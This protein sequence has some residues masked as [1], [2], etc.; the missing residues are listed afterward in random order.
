[1]KLKLRGILC[2]LFFLLGTQLCF[3]RQVILLLVDR[4][5]W[6]ELAAWQDQLPNFRWLMQ[7]GALGLL[8]TRTERGTTQ[9]SAY[10]TIGA[11]NRAVGHEGV[12]AGYQADELVEK[13]PAAVVYARRIGQAAAKG[14]VLA[15]ELGAMLSANENSDYGAEPGT[16]GSAIHRAG[17]K[18]AV[19]GCGDTLDEIHRPHVAI[20]MDQAGLVDYGFVSKKLLQKD[21]HAPF[22]IATDR[23]ALLA[24]FEQ[25]KTKADFIVIDFGDTSRVE[26]Y[27]DFL[28]AEMLARQRL[29]A[30]KSA[31][32]FLGSLRGLIDWDKTQLLLAT[33]TPNLQA[34]KDGR[35]LTPV[36]AIGKGFGHGYLMGPTTRRPAVVTN[37][38]L[39][40]TVLRGLGIS[41]LP[42]GSGRAFVSKAHPEPLT[43]LLRHSSKLVAQNQLRVPFNQA[44]VFFLILVIVLATC[45]VFADTAGRLTVKQTSLLQKL[46]LAAMAVP[47][48]TLLLPSLP[49]SG[50]W[51]VFPE[52]ILVTALVVWLLGFFGSKRSLLA[53][54]LLTV[55]ALC[56]DVLL[57]GAQLQYSFLGY[58]AIIGARFYGIGNE[59]MGVLIG[60]ALVAMAGLVER[61]C[62]L[63]SVFLFFFFVTAVIGLPSLGANVGGT[64]T[65]VAA[66]VLAGLRLSER[67]VKAKQGFG[68][69]GAVVLAVL[70]MA[71]F[72]RYLGSGSSH[73][74]SG[75]KYL[76]GGQ[77]DQIFLI[78]IRKL[79]MNMRLIRV[80][81]WSRVLLFF[82]AACVVLVIR[83]QG[84]LKGLFGRKKSFASGFYAAA[85]GTIVAFIFNDSGVVAA[86]TLMIFPVLSLFFLL[87]EKEG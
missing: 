76:T 87:V 6:E 17:K 23:R 42:Q 48:V 15:V 30:L 85:L 52:V 14:S 10:L 84:V 26:A 34:M 73:L 35:R 72:D 79:S 20:A 31:D 64:I 86:A 16:L 50:T 21:P 28:T 58:S 5:S 54:S 33:P 62:R 3:G 66:F 7:E 49:G 8:N 40:P 39:A 37:V 9:E 63:R 24:A 47:A 78:I 68:I 4:V 51:V 29:Y 60:A 80:T 70:A 12:A 77:W 27:R 59:F 25:V 65:A 69:V 56:I 71:L 74:A 83:P 38:D 61:G 43:Y 2:L 82:L 44:Y 41:R 55:A 18:T 75:M 45:G 22:G 81:I 11:G 19:L 46:L 1:M 32:R 36:M 53:L 13:E 67:T 57:G